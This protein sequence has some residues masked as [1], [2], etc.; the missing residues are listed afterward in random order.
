MGTTVNKN[1]CANNG[2]KL[3][4]ASHIILYSSY[5][6]T[7]AI[8]HNIKKESVMTGQLAIIHPRPPPT[9]ESTTK[10]TTRTVGVSDHNK[11]K[12]RCWHCGTIGHMQREY[13][14]VI[15]VETV[16]VYVV[17]TLVCV[18]VITPWVTLEGG[19]ILYSGNL[20]GPCH[21]WSHIPQVA[22]LVMVLLVPQA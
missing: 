11:D 8:G 6:P 19:D 13:G 18:A 12:S 5:M 4:S 1:A 3:N 7:G 16:V 2:R 17:R 20:S 14:G 15:I 9:H 21:N 10:D 22:T